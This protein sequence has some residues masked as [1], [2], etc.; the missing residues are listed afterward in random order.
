VTDAIQKRISIVTPAWKEAE[1][2]PVLHERLCN[3]LDEVEGDW[4]W[5][6]VDDHSPDDTFACIYALSQKDPRVKGVRLSR[7]SGSH[8]ALTCGLNQV[9]GDCA[10]LIAGDLQDP[11]ETIPALLAKRDEGLQV[12]W[13]VRTA[14]PGETITTKGFSRLYYWIMRKIVGLKDIP[15]A[16]ADFLLMDRKVVDAFNRFNESNV[17]IMSLITWMGFKQGRIEYVK[18]ARL[19]G[20]SGWTFRTKFKLVIDSIT[21]FTYLPIRLMSITGFAVALLGFVYAIYVAYMRITQGLTTGFAATMIAILVIG[22]LQMMMMGVLGEYLW[23]SLD[24]SR[25]R[26]RYLIEE[27]TQPMNRARDNE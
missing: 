25:K 6:I 1:N 15:A 9:E 27:E 5:I 21:S 13:A 10:I 17:S 23:R 3:V 12:V 20:E 18:E 7:N 24:E 11:P 19:H 2:L 22:G 4:E 16:G 26:P 14:R 8:V